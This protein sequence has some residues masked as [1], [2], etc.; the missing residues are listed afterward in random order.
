M[1]VSESRREAIRRHYRMLRTATGKTQ[2]QVEAQARLAA[3]QYWRIENGFDFPTDEERAR[4]ARVLKTSES[5][6]PTLHGA[7]EAK[8]S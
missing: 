4:L 7:A 2:L 6:I 8:A 5:N 3:G 1:G